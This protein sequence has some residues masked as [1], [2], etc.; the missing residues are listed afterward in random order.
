[1]IHSN[2]QRRKVFTLYGVWF[3]MCSQ[4]H[5]KWDK[6]HWNCQYTHVFVSIHLSYSYVYVSSQIHC[7][8]FTFFSKFRQFL[9]RMYVWPNLSLLAWVKRS[10]SKRQSLWIWI[11]N[12]NL[13]S[14]LNW[15]EWNI[16]HWALMPFKLYKRN[17]SDMHF[18]N[19]LVVFKSDSSELR[20]HLIDYR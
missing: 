14:K 15:N 13:M 2:T 4:I 7:S 18:E 6:H 10:V 17:S 8:V 1:M 5:W 16:H 12:L 11:W 3:E 20:F 9:R 19:E